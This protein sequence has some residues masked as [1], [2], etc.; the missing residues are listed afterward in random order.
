MGRSLAPHRRIGASGPRLLLSTAIVVSAGLA[1]VPAAVAAPGDIT[2]AAGTGT[3]GFSGD[4]GPA[5]SAELNFSTGVA[6]D[7]SGNLYI[8]DA[9]NCRVRKVDGSG[10]ITTVAGAG[11]CAFSGDGGPATSAGLEPYGVAVD[12]SGNLYLADAGNQRVRKVD[13]SGTITT[14]A[15]TGTA[16]FSGDGGPA[17]SAQLNFPVGVAVDGSGNL[18][19]ADS[20]NNRVRKVDGSGTITTVAGTG[21]AGFS[22]DGGAAASAQ[23]NQP[24]GVAVDGSGN[25]Y[26]GDWNN[27]RVRKVDGSGTITTVAGTGTTGFSGDGGPATSAELI[28]PQGV[29]VDGSGN[30][31]IP[32][33][34]QARV[35]MVNG[36]GTI[37]TVAGTGTAGFSGDGGPATSAQLNSPGWAA[38]D[39]SGN[40]FIADSVNNRVRKVEPDAVPPETTITSGPS[41]ATNDDTPSF[42]FSSSEPGSS[43]GC[44]VDSGPYEACGSPK[45]TAPLGNGP[46]TF[47]VRATDPGGNTDPSPATRTFTV[48]T[49]PPNTTITSGPSG[50]TND[51]TPTFTFTAS[52][53][54]S[55]FECKLDG[56]SY[57]ACVSPKTYGAL[58]DGPHTFDVRAED[59][60]GNVD[61]TPATRT[62]TVDTVPPNT[63]ITSGPSGAT[64]DPTPTFAFTSSDI[65]STFQCKLDAGAY[66]ACTSPRTLAH[67]ADGSHT[68]YVRARDS[69]GNLDPTPASRTF[70]VST[71]EVR[72]SGSTLVVT[73]A[74]G[75]KDNLVITKPSASTLRVTDS[76]S[77]AYTGS[78]V[79]TG[80]GCTRSGDY[81][82]NCNASGITLIQVTSGDQIDQVTNSTAVKSSLNGGAA[83]DVLTG[84]SNNDTLTG[85]TGADVFRGMNGNDQLFARDLTSETTINCDGGT[86]PGGADKADLD[87]L[88]KD[89]N[90]RVIG[91]ETKT[92]H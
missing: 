31:Y 76:P 26:I 2:T 91:C 80:A 1:A 42:T 13:G 88:P 75:A 15:G 44:K 64:N 92:R 37:T 83:N 55:T 54:S 17:T 74:A 78:G 45:T 89:P 24:L 58:T 69:S 43:F 7:G 48:D 86:S 5:T 28:Q 22:G 25:L 36:S 11:A 85:S 67:L 50:A 39:G 19:I 12:G 61:P 90:A 82:A 68:F 62:F 73:A 35:R 56:G 3:A 66:A 30:L 32:T 33:P 6:V 29:A 14:V 23:L 4:G 51:P 46:H 79:R 77:G 71:A 72:I 84:G 65:G 18:Y 40:L 60:A 9:N 87:V 57:L 38:V 52:Q 63:T 8:G 21:T 53:A 81:T 49:V 16:G 41:G 10:T 70:T 20:T 59:P 34:S 27:H 47:Y